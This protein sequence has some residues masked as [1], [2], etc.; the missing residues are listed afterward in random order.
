MKYKNLGIKPY[1]KGLLELGNH[2][3]AYLQP[4]GGWGWSNAGLIADSEQAIVVDTLF[5]E[6]LTESML[7]Q[8]ESAEPKAMQDIV[9]LIN[10][11]SNGDHCNGNNCV[12]T[13]EIICTDATLEEMQHESPEM[14]ASLLANHAE[15]GPLGEYFYSCFGKFDF[16][17]VTRKLPNKTF[18]G[19]FEKSVGSLKVELDE[20]GPC[21][22][23]GDL[24]VYVPEDNVIFTGDILFIEGHPIIWAGPV[25]NWIDACEK[26]IQLD[27]EAVVPGHGPVTD[28]K[29]VAAVRDYLRYIHK[30]AK[31]RFE[32][33][34]TALEAAKDIE[35]SDFSSWGDAER[36]AV[37]VNSLYREFKGESIREDITLLFSQMAELAGYSNEA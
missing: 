4:D 12:K 8:M 33:G 29:G 13:K 35:F 34:L 1:N 3:Y 37:N 21:H 30:E 9:S 28:K 5:D 19:S 31:S 24:L 25:Q 32:A 23:N 16:A 6:G 7:N 26:I 11:H 20:V 14:M 27:P 17:G 2:T 10:S 15:L 36:I 22:T 18:S